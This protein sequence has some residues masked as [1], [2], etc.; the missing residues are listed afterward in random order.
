MEI[1]PSNQ[2]ALFVHLVQHEYE[3]ADGLEDVKII[4]VFSSE[5]EAK[6][7]IEISKRLAGFSR[8]PDGYTIDKYRLNELHWKEGFQTM[9]GFGAVD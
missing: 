1:D 5:S 6:K 2:V 4:G 8:N 9:N 7:A 3:N